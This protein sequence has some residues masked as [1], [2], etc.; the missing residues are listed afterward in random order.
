MCL[1]EQFS[2]T[3]KVERK[4]RK[5]ENSMCIMLDETDANFIL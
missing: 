4:K 2:V 1:P 3:V 5:K